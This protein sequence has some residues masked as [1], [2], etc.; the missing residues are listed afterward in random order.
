MWHKCLLVFQHEPSFPWS[1][2]VKSKPV[3]LCLKDLGCALSKRAL[4]L[5]K[6]SQNH[7]QSLK[8]ETHSHPG[9]LSPTGCKTPTYLLTLPPFIKT[10]LIALYLGS[11]SSAG[12]SSDDAGVGGHL[13]MEV[14]SGC[15]DVGRQHAQH[16]GQNRRTP[17]ITT[18]S[19]VVVIYHHHNDADGGSQDATQAIL[20]C[21]YLSLYSQNA[22][23]WVPQCVCV[24]VCVCI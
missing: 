22:C 24:C 20:S 15:L 6:Y 9:T 16:Y 19:N 2:L 10:T 18:N 14:E 1:S 11:I 5:H 4:V 23:V 17:E 8:K 13:L 3:W 12:G 21:V 7:T